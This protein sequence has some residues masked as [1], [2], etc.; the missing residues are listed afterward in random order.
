[1]PIGILVHPDGKRAYVANAD[2]VAIV[3]LEAWK[4][5]G[6]L[7]AGKEPDGMAYSR[8]APD[9]DRPPAE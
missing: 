2:V 7:K 9:R 5:V 8:R 3:D 1:V 4:V 6:L